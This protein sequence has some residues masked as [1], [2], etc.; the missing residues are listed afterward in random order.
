MTYYLK[1]KMIDVLD[2]CER[3][4]FSVWQLYDEME[5]LSES[6]FQ[7]DYPVYEE[8]DPNNVHLDTIYKKMF[9]RKHKKSTKNSSEMA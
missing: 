7:E 2:R 5:F 8:N 6:M 3:K 1:D 4:E 9:T